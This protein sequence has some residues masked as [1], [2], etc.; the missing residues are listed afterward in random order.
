MAV[1]WLVPLIIA[2]ILTNTII[3]IV[4]F[5]LFSM[6][7]CLSVKPYVCNI[8]PPYGV[9]VEAKRRENEAADARIYR[10]F[11]EMQGMPVPV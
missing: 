5:T 3:T 10:K 7:V 4:V 1:S 6:Y 9:A 2:I 8:E 11:Y